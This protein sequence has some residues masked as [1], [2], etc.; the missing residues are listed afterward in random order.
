MSGWDER[1]LT[2]VVTL[3]SA[4]VHIKAAALSTFESRI[5]IAIIGTIS[6]LANIMLWTDIL[7]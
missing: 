1:F 5:T 7:L 4:F 2:G 6:I 3:V